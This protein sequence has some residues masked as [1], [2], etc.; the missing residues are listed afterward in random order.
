MVSR[1]AGLGMGASNAEIPSF[2]SPPLKVVPVDGVLQGQ[3]V[4]D[5][6]HGVDL[7]PLGPRGPHHLLGVGLGQHVLHGGKG[8]RI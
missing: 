2:N 5:V 6:D 1:E 3:L 7:L 4:E 8:E